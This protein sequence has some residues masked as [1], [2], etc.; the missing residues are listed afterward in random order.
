MNPDL[1][2]SRIRVVLCRPAHPGNIGA[3]A[4]AMKTMGLTHLHLVTPKSFPDQVATDRAA[5]ADDLLEAA[6]CHKSIDEALSGVHFALG[7][8]AR[9]R[10]LGPQ[11]EGVRDGVVRLVEE[12]ARG[13]VALVFGNEATG[14]S[15]DELLRCHAVAKIPTNPDFSSLNL[16]AAV[17]V[18]SYEVRMAILGVNGPQG[19]EVARSSGIPATNAELEGFYG[20]LQE[21]MTDTGFFNPEQPG[22][23]MQKIRKLFGRARLEREEINILRGVLA[24]AQTPTGHAGCRPRGKGQDN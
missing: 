5:G 24:S 13:E 1:L 3:A 14:M 12:A 16:G 10:D 15:N 4:R 22:R 11:Q 23:L 9:T 6:Q 7:M 21:L 18:L 17:Q 19:S 8:S 2:L 20:H